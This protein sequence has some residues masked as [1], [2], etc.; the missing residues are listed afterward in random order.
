MT[1]SYSPIICILE[2]QEPEPLYY[3]L[4]RSLARNRLGT[5]HTYKQFQNKETDP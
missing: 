2:I 3:S 5:L 4:E 1:V